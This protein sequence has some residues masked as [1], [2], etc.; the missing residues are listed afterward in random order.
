[1]LSVDFVD[2]QQGDAAVIETSAGTRMLID[3]GENQLFARYLANRYPWGGAEEPTDESPELPIEAIVVTHGDADH[4]AGLRCI[5]A[6]ETDDRP[7]KRVRISPKAIYHNGLVKGKKGEGARMLGPCEDDDAGNGKWLTR[8]VDDPREL[9]RKAMNGPFAAWCK[10]M[11]RYARRR[12]P[13]DPLHVSRLDS[14]ST[15]QFAPF[16]KDGLQVQVLGPVLRSVM[17]N[18]KLTPALPYLGTPSESINGHSIVLKMTYGRCRFLFTGDIN[19]R[20]VAGLGDVGE[21]AFECEVLKAPHHGSGDFSPA[22][23]RSARPL[24]SVISSGDENARVEYVHPRAT[25]LGALGRHSRIE[26]PIIFVTEMVAFFN[27]E[28]YVGPDWHDMTELGVA[29]AKIA[30]KQVVSVPTRKKYFSFSRKAW[31]TVHVRTDG[32]RLLVWTDS[33][34]E[35]LKEAYCIDLMTDP[36]AMTEVVPQ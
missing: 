28:G 9:P 15:G 30:K 21:S 5:Q 22:F 33:A 6:S 34:L 10:A 14:M 7:A 2:V 18:G 8:L 29:Q 12:P 20:A 11:D 24:V 4:F 17:I 26:T 36:P 19:T 1:V 3:G 23:L 25:L 16:E 32:K 35:R 27:V 31:G 13:D